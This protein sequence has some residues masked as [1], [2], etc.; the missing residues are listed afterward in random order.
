MSAQDRLKAVI[1]A[2]AFKS[3]G[4][5]KLTEAVTYRPAGNS[6]NDRSIEA[7]VKRAAAQP[8]GAARA[9]VITVKV[10]NDA[11]TGIS[12]DELDT[13]TDQILLAERDGESAAAR[14]IAKLLTHNS[15]TISFE[16]R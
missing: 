3:D 9:P 10:L 8:Y 1:A 15:A 7:V 2:T 12:S 6:D 14:P 13:G 11:S 16:L 5:T 4:A